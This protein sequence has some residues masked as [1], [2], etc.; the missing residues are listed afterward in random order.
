VRSPGPRTLLAI[1]VGLGVVLL[2]QGAVDVLVAR[3]IFPTVSMPGFDIAPDRD[4]RAAL[5]ELSVYAHTADGSRTEVKPEDLM[6][7][8]MYSA[9]RATLQRFV[10]YEEGGP[11]DDDTVRWL[12][13]NADAITDST[14]DELEFVWQKD[15]FDIVTL[16]STPLE[17]PEIVRISR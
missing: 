11:L 9:V 10:R 17:E 12:F 16:T 2:A 1:S 7:P 6:S 14:V 13:A 3:T 8:M 4:G 15:E 5:T